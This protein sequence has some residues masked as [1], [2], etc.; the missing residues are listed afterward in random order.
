MRN[1]RGK[2]IL[3]ACAAAL[4]LALVLPTLAFAQFAPESS[5]TTAAEATPAPADTVWTP[6][7][8]NFWLAT[9]ETALLNVLIWS[10]N[11]YIRPGGGEGFKIG[12]ESWWENIRNG[13]EWD[14]NNFDTNQFAHPYHGSTYFNA[15]RSNG[16]NYWESW[17]FAWAGSWMWEYLME[18]HHASINDWIATSVGGAT[19]GESLHRFSNAILDNTATGSSRTWRELGGILVNPVNGFTRLVTGD[20]FRVHPNPP[21]R[22]PNTFYSYLN[23]GLRTIGEERIWESDTTR[24]YIRFGFV[25]GDPFRGAT[26]KP[27]DHF[28]LHAQINFSDRSA[29]GELHAEGLLTGGTIQESKTSKSLLGAF[30]HFTYFNNSAYEFGAQSFSAGF[31]NKFERES[32]NFHANLNAGAILMGAVKSHYPSFTGRTYDY[33]P[34]VAF[35]FRGSFERA[36]WDYLKIAHATSFIH[37]INGNKSDHIV[38]FTNVALSVPIHRVVGAGV[39]Y[40][41]YLSD[42]EYEDFPDVSQRSPEVRLFFAY[43]MN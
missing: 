19:L 6:P 3:G 33:G 14:D 18:T 41:L 7:N 29:I 36:G 37:T 8:R 2:V 15:G 27:F 17:A 11:R 39:E 38:S 26:K 30:Q 22:F 4:L 9:G 13:F 23:A 24:A 40:L 31:L 20:M 21:D 16:Y 1:G 28:N 35:R 25:Y 5:D 34:G 32:F 10:Y 12:T 43:Q 42:S